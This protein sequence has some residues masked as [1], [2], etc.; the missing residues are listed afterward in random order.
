MKLNA[1]IITEKLAETKA[2]YTEILNFGV[3]FENDF[4]LLLHTPNREAEIS[5]LL[6]NHPSQ[7]PIF[8]A[9][10]QNQGVY[11]TIEVENVDEVYNKLKNKNIPIEIELR[12]EPWGDR[13]FAIKDPNDIGVDIVTYSEPN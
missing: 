1:G 13:H 3:T 11:I 9:S 4:Y 2:F 12:N 8:Q 10:F 7:Q 6:P 5:F